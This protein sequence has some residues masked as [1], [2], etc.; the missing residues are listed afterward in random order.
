MCWALVGGQHVTVAANVGNVGWHSH[1]RTVVSSCW[2]SFYNH[3]YADLTLSL[4]V[5]SVSSRR[6][7]DVFVFCLGPQVCYVLYQGGGYGGLG[8]PAVGDRGCVETVVYD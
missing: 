3:S 5:A 6:I 1:E 7:W 4:H 8:G 2:E